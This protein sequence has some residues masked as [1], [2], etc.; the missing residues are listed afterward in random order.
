[1]LV[2]QV[3]GHVQSCTA[4]TFEL[5]QRVTL[6][7]RYGTHITAVDLIHHRRVTGTDTQVEIG[8]HRCLK[9]LVTAENATAVLCF[10]D[11]NGSILVTPFEGTAPYTLSVDNFATSQTVPQGANYNFSGLT[12]GIY[13]ASVRDAHGCVATAEFE[14]ATP[15]ELS[16]LETSTTDPLCFEGSDGEVVVS[17][18]GGV[19]PYRITVDGTAYANN[20]GA[21]AQTISNLSAGS[22]TIVLTDANSCTATITSTL[23]E[24][25]LLEL[26]QVDITPITCHGGADGTVTV[27]VSGGTATYNVT[28]DGGQ[29]QTLNSAAETALFTDLDSG[30]HTVLVTD[31]HGC[32]APLTVNFIEPDPMS[33]VL[34]A[35]TDVSCF[36]LSDGTATFTISGGTLPY[37]V[38][39]DSTL[40][41]IT[42]NS[43]DPYTISVLWANVY[44]VHILD[45]HGC[46]A[47]MQITIQEPDTLDAQARVVNH[48]YCFGRQDG[49][50]T[51]DVEGGTVPYNYAWSDDS[52]DSDLTN[53]GAGFYVVTVSDYNGCI[54]ADTV[55]IEEPELLSIELV[56]LTESCAG[57]A[58][59]VIDIDALGGT[60]DYQFNWSNGATTDSIF[61]LAVGPYTVTVTDMNGCTDTMT[62][63]VPYHALP[64]FTVSV[65]DAYCDRNDGTATVVGENTNLYNY[66]WHA[67][68]NPNAPF[69]GQLYGGDYILTVDDTV[70]T[71]DIPFHIE[72]IPGPTA[73]FT[74]DPTTF[75]QGST[76]RYND[77]SI[78]S[79]VT[80]EYEF[81]DGVTEQS[82]NAI[83]LYQDEGTYWTVLTVTDEHNC[84]DTAMQL[85]TVLPD[86]IIYIPNAFTPNGDGMN[87]EWAPII[88]NYGSDFYE[89]IVYSRWGEVMFKSNAP[90]ATWNG[91]HNGKEAPVGVYTYVLTYQNVLGKNYIKDGTVTIIR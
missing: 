76:V 54:A 86:V 57:E 78:G 45:D 73:H 66:D 39:V 35:S 82:P 30:D 29:Q 16:L 6:V 72:N 42:L 3:V 56:T 89:L 27:A 40:A 7:D 23:G 17:L 36:G 69:N 37:I 52:H 85:I 75:I 55:L 31:D 44:D 67:E 50:A 12:A 2:F 22:H 25:A 46:T 28:I 83:H 19:E 77:Q 38:S 87:D 53:V 64:D 24:P 90:H 59:A 1:M 43:E 65:T 11:A 14:I 48:V 8:D 4:A 41:D 5:L 61:D 9:L 80:W 49:N 84:I 34:N 26:A 13:T 60:P 88:S 18:A 10:G 32:T 81:G 21:G 91:K 68:N 62:V 58:T 79:V 63:E 20:L 15:D 47:Q 70:C 51:V 74:A 33:T 71:L